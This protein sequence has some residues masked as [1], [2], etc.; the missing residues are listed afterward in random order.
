MASSVIRLPGGRVEKELTGEGDG[1]YKTTD[2]VNG[3]HL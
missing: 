2:D 1:Q 3:L